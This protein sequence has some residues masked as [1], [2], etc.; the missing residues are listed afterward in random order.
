MQATI[1]LSSSKQQQ[2]QQSHIVGEQRQQMK[3][4]WRIKQERT[5]G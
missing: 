5:K 3:I 4:V 1:F 2:Q